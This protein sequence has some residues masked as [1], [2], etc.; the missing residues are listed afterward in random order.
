MLCK[1]EKSELL[2]RRFSEN[3]QVD[4]LLGRASQLKDFTWSWL[5]LS[6]KI[7]AAVMEDELELQS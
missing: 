7:S 1:V 3:F 4:H 2:I 6:E 5:A